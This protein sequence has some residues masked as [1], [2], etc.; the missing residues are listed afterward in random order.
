MLHGIL[1]PQALVMNFIYGTLTVLALVAAVRFWGIKWWSFVLSFI[2]AFILQGG[3]THIILSLEG[4]S[5][6]LDVVNVISTIIDATVTGLLIYLGLVVHLRKK[7]Y[8][9]SEGYL[10]KG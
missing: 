5:L 3:I 9:V 2:L 10:I 1:Q 8:S 6:S 7:G 4:K